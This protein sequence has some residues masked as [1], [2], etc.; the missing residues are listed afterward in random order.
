MTARQLLSEGRLADAIRRLELDVASGPDDVAGR[1]FLFELLGFAG[2]FDRAEEQLAAIRQLD[3]RPAAR[4]G[5]EVYRQLL[6]GERA[7]ARLFEHGQPPQFFSQPSATATLHLEALAL[8]LVDAKAAAIEKIKEANTRQPSRRG[9]AGGQ[10]IENLRDADDLLGP[11]LEVITAGGYH[12]VPWADIQ[13]LSVPPPR[14]LRDLL[15]A[16]ARIAT[17]DGMLGEV[18][19]PNIYPGSSGHADEAVR[20]GRVTVWSN[21]DEGFVRGA[22]QKLFFAGE[23]PRT[24]FEIGEIQFSPVSDMNVDSPGEST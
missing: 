24:L 3:Q 13:F 20:L 22:G 1:T 6:D 17:V 16:P 2:E 7:R 19:L 4:T 23:E 10:V 11:I 8:Y 12:W 18:Y 9:S 15:W 5:I 14:D 21:D